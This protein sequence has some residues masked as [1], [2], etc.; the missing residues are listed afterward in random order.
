MDVNALR[1][2][3]IAVSAALI[4]GALFISAQPFAE[5]Q[6][7]PLAQF[8]Q[9]PQ[10]EHVGFVVR[11]RGE[12]PIA[13]AQAMAARGNQQQAQ[14]QIEAQLVRQTAFNGLCFDR[15]TVG[16][17]EVVLRSCQPVAA[18]ERAAYQDR[19]VRRLRAM[20]SIAYADANAAA[21]QN[22]GG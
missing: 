18:S 3:G 11:F 13:R 19:W 20:R 2:W 14:R 12:G 15:F 5:A 4:S 16:A 8:A 7:S 6:T 21:S 17:A 10:P 1:L 22:R 9:A